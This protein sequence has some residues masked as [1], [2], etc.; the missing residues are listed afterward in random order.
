MLEMGFPQR[1]FADILGV[2]QSVV[3]RLWSRLQ[4]TGRY[5]RRPGQG[6]GRCTTEEYGRYVRTLAHRNRESTA[7][8]IQ[9]EFQIAIRRRLYDQIMTFL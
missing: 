1:Q 8:R 6:R 5:T 4:E 9:S 7:T 3:A 2:S